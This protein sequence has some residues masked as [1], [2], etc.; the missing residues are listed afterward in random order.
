MA[1]ESIYVVLGAV[2]G[3]V[4][5]I[6]SAQPSP[7]LRYIA[8]ISLPLLTV[9]VLL[10]IGFRVVTRGTL[11]RVRH[12][13]RTWDSNQSPYPGLEP[14][15]EA[16]VAVF[17]G[18]ERAIDEVVDRLVGGQSGSSG[19]LV[20]V[21]GASG[22]GK[23]SLIQAGVLPRL[24]RLRRKWQVLATTRPSVDPVR[25]LCMALVE[26]LPSRD[27]EA[28]TQEIQSGQVGFGQAFT[29]ATGIQ[30]SLDDARLLV[31]DQ[32]E[33]LFTLADEARR[34]EFFGLLRS[35]LEADQSLYVVGALRSEFLTDLLSSSIATLVRQ[36]V[37]ISPM[38]RKSLYQVVE[39]PAKLVGLTFEDGLVNRMVNEVETGDALP[40]LA[41]IL[42]ELYL[43]VGRNA[44]ITHTEYELL[45]GVSGALANR[46]D[47]T[48]DQVGRDKADFV[49]EVMLS[50]VTIEG[51]EPA[52]RP[53]R[54]SELDDAAMDVVAAF[55]SDRILT[56]YSIDG[57]RY[58]AVAHEA[59]FN[60]WAPL[61]QAI[62]VRVETLRRRAQLERWA[63][64]WEA[65]GR[66]Q[67]YL[68][69]GERLAVIRQWAAAPLGKPI[70]AA[71]MEYLDASYH[72]D[73]AAMVH[74]ADS[75]AA[76]ALASLKVNP[77]KAVLLALA[78]V[79]ELVATQSVYRALWAAVHA[80]RLR[81]VLQGHSD[82]VFD[83]AWSP[84]QDIL[85]TGSRDG[86]IILW[87]G[88]SG[89]APSD[90]GRHRDWVFGVA[91][92]ATGTLLA[93]CSRDR[94]VCLWNVRD[95]RLERSVSLR[96]PARCMDWDHAHREIVVATD[97]GSVCVFDEALGELRRILCH[98]RE[99]RAVASSHGGGRIA[100]GSTDG[101]VRIWDR[102]S[103]Q[104]LTQ[105][106]AHTD[107]IHCLAWSPDGRTLLSGSRDRTA[108]LWSGAD[109][110][111]LCRLAHFGEEVRC[112]SWSP[113]GTHV[114]LGLH[115]GT[116]R[117]WNAELT[118][119]VGLLRGHEDWI[120][121]AAWS[122]TSDLIA[123]GAQDHTVRLWSPVADDQGTTI[124]TGSG[125]V[126]CICWS[127]D[128]ELLASGSSDAKART[129]TA[130]GELASVFE[131]HQ[132]AIVGLHWS[133]D[134]RRLAT[135]SRDR[136]ARVWQLEQPRSPIVLR[137]H[138]NDVLAVRWSPSGDLLATA[139]QDRLVRIWDPLRPQQPTATLQW[140]TDE[141]TSVDWSPDH[142][143]LASCSRDRMVLVWNVDDWTVSAELRGHADDVFA[144]SWSPDA[145][146]LASASRDRTVRIWH[147]TRW[148]ELA[149]L[150]GHE[151]EV[152]TLGWA[153][154]GKWLATGSRDRTWRLWGTDDWR[155]FPVYGDHGDE[156]R[157]LAWSPEGVR[158]ATAGRD[159]AIRFWNPILDLGALV[160]LARTRVFRQLTA[161][162][163]E[164]FIG[165]SMSQT[166]GVTGAGPHG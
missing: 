56:S 120:R 161:E 89:Y 72:A 52:R 53:L 33:E 28:L 62:E 105:L 122:A 44:L 58:V 158:L 82:W 20:I 140:H 34:E 160:D 115:D 94:T 112:A 3:L 85:A 32:M 83:V 13:D 17:F 164:L 133:P 30:L 5:N 12:S 39:G 9:I 162:E 107:W 68:L 149:V 88:R 15:T 55:V 61:R 77:E 136:T 119:E 143:W 123:T 19:R 1:A 138:A 125:W 142:K 27:A 78:A 64:E 145:A 60:A 146:L 96:A 98:D 126:N 104:L 99:V 102:S 66:Q 51:R 117:I 23:S 121:C 154:G 165:G 153:T 166:L 69:S 67:A 141:V 159:S 43:R 132:D 148:T 42:Q 48:L 114:V 24:A 128:G 116:A 74:T 31:V 36:P 106:A 37:T 49:I 11:S 135:A 38:D 25:R 109:G 71:A 46:A 7:M 111:L 6:A 18:R 152:L 2:L 84:A 29:R 100:T 65:S 137:D 22:V 76:H 57:E 97:D 91:W 41:Y 147:A 16:D 124:P 35:A 129:W 63:A 87:D 70:G 113:D 151:D 156:I 14:F 110:S 47:R 103:G 127:P 40:L 79:D 163:R 59:L 54:Q 21:I 144:V 93:S 50:F 86:G 45:G 101:S 108:C 95:R 150:N 80:C 155:E 75:I 131:G 73:H 130:V 118:R 8:R 157:S 134:G 26:K 92:S 139:S 81:G 90:L 4:T 10:L